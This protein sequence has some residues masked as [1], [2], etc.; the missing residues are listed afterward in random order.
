MGFVLLINVDNKFHA[1]INLFEYVVN[2]FNKQALQSWWMAN[3]SLG[4]N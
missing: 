4:T 3:E 2:S 1:I